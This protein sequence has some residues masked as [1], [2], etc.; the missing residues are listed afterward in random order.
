MKFGALN[1]K[2][3]LSRLLIGLI[4]ILCVSGYGEAWGG[5]ESERGRV[6][7]LELSAFYTIYQLS[8]L[9]YVEVVCGALK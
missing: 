4:S 9:S 1:M 6:G 5:G 8:S 3:L 2:R 7:P